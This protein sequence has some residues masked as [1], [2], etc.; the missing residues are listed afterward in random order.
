MY[1]YEYLKDENYK[2]Y[3]EKRLNIIAYQY[4]FQKG[5][6]WLVKII[7]IDAIM[8]MRLLRLL[9]HFFREWR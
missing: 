4:T 2:D 5:K 7:S 1:A 6:K 3:V 9:G 8:E